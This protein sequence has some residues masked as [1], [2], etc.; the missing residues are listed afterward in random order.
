MVRWVWAAEDW[1]AGRGDE[2]LTL[3]HAATKEEALRAGVAALGAESW[4]QEDEDGLVYGALDE[5]DPDGCWLGR[6]VLLLVEA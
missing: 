4:V 1:Q 5:G 3:G 2:Q 6:V